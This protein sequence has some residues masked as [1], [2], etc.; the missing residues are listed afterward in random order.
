M[1]FYCSCIA[2]YVWTC[3][4]TIKNLFTTFLLILNSS[5]HF[6]MLPIYQQIT[7]NTIRGF[8]GRCRMCLHLESYIFSTNPSCQLDFQSKVMWSTVNSFITMYV[9]VKFC[10][11]IITSTVCGSVVSWQLFFVHFSTWFISQIYLVHIQNEMFVC[12]LQQEES[13]KSWVANFV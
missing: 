9:Y 13:K 10:C 5:G 8:M 3:G 11:I 4:F 6:P 7:S 1:L 2:N 12:C